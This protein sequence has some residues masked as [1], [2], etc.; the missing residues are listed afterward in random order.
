MQPQQY[1]CVTSHRGPG[2]DAVTLE[3]V[4]MPTPCWYPNPFPP[5]FPPYQHYLGGFSPSLVAFSLLLVAFSPL[6]VAFSPP[7]PVAFG[8][9]G[10]L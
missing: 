2:I 6:S 10:G 3:E 4:T 5:S 8:S 9:F 7:Q 1:H